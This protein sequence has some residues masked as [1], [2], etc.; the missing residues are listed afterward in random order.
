MKKALLTTALFLTMSQFGWAQTSFD[1]AKLDNYFQ[2]LE[3]NNK[4]MGSVAVSQNGQIIYSKSIGFADVEKNQKANENTKYRI[5]SITKTFTTVLVLKAIED[6]KL[7]LDQTIEKFFPTVP[8]ANKITIKQLLGHRSGI[9]NF[10]NDEDYLT[11]YT[12]PKTEKE[13]VEHITKIGSDFEPDSKA[14]YSNSN[15]VLLT[16]ILEKIHKQSYADVVD[17]Q[18]IKPLGLKNTKFGG[19]IN[20]TNNESKSYSYAGSWKEEPET[21]MSIPLGAGGIISTPTD[22]TQFS[23]ALFGGKLLKPESLELMKTVVDGYGLGLFKVPFYDKIGFGHTGGI[24]NFTSMFSYF[25]DGNISYAL[26]SNGT[27]YNN[28]NISIAVLSAIYGKEYDIPEF[29]SYEVKAEEL[30]QYLGIYSSTTIPIK[31]TITKEDHTL[32][33]QATGQSAFPLEATAKDQFKFDLAGVVIEFKPAEK[34]LLLKQGGMEFT[35]IKP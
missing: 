17:K 26:T 11:W 4:F 18:I 35:F 10:T 9:H 19:K 13:M 2:N 8:N 34:T 21:D 30:E 6:K 25:P 16:Y 33:A 5:G 22:L 31:I 32:F 29:S 28:N 7:S 15:Y 20:T 1:K 24:D 27:N 3:A 12:Q 14:D 23:D